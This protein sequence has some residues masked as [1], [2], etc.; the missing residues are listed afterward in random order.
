MVRSPLQLAGPR[1]TSAAT[2]RL[3]PASMSGAEPGAMNALAVP[4][5]AAT[6]SPAP[7]S[8]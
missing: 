7:E 1:S 6:M 4:M 8:W 3:L 5:L 2:S